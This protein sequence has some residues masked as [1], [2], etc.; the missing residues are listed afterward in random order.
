MPAR[1]ATSSNRADA[2]PFAENS[3]SAASRMASR[4]AAALALRASWRVAAMTPAPGR[5]GLAPALPGTDDAAR[6]GRFAAFGMVLIMTDWS[7]I[8]KQSPAVARNRDFQR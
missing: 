8:V 7:V 1:L 4:R 5:A 3:S 2:N 6:A